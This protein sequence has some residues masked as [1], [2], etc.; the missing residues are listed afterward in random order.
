MFKMA[1][2]LAG[3]DTVQRPDVDSLQ[4]S[5]Y[6]KKK[7]LMVLRNA[8]ISSFEEVPELLVEISVREYEIKRKLGYEHAQAQVKQK[9]A[10][11]N[12]LM[13]NIQHKKHKLKYVFFYLT[14]IILIFFILEWK[15]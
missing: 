14:Y 15:L 3:S 8:R 4:R 5:I 6:Q 12:K 2:E 10:K 11:R 1:E 9:E 7:E 13:K